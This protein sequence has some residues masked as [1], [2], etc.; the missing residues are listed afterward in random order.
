MK[1]YIISDE[2]EKFYYCPIRND[3]FKEIHPSHLI[4]DKQVTIGCLSQ[5]QKSDPTAKIVEYEL[6]RIQSY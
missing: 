2:S 5:A 3:W 1:F 4:Q 6:L